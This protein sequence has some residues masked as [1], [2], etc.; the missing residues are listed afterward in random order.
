MSIPESQQQALV[1]RLMQSCGGSYTPETRRKYFISGPQW[2]AAY[3]GQALFHA[4]TRPEIGFQE[5]IRKYGE[6]G[7]GYWCT[8]DTDVIP[9]EAMGTDRQAQIVAEIQNA[10]REN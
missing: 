2:A 3:Q 9:T 4:P 8:H 6:I 5:I 10:L 1:T 7:I